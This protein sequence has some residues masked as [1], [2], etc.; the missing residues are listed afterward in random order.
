MAGAAGQTR[1]GRVGYS[2]PASDH[3][4]GG[5]RAGQP[6]KLRVWRL[7]YGGQP[8]PYLVV[9]VGSAGPGGC[10]H[11]VPGKTYSVARAQAIAEHRERCESA[12]NTV[13]RGRSRP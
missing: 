12:K 2:F 11:D 5:T 10:D 6:V 8:P 4:G 9:P 3:A 1:Y 7:D 13:R